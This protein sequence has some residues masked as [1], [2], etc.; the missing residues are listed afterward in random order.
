MK[1]F[2]NASSAEDPATLEQR[3]KKFSNEPEMLEDN[4]TVQQR[5]KKFGQVSSIMVAEDPSVV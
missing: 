2:G 1:K 5:L 4:E 3:K